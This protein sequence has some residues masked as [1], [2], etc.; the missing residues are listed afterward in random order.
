MLWKKEL[1]K[2]LLA[3]N[4]ELRS[5]PLLT[6]EKDCTKVS[7]AVLA[8]ASP[9]STNKE[10]CTIRH[11]NFDLVDKS[12][13]EWLCQQCSKGALVSGVLWGVF[14]V[15]DTKLTL[16]SVGRLPLTQRQRPQ[17]EL[18]YS[19]SELHVHVTLASYPGVPIPIWRR[20]EEER[21]VHTVM[22][23]RLI[24]NQLSRTVIILKIRT[25]N[26]NK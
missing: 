23:M 19:S 6:F 12:L 25:P 1:C 5:V 3:R 2:K 20:G 9:T 15:P 22:R 17:G 14:W 13:L 18:Y 4:L 10:C 24:S 26:F 7:D 16:K 11:A 8:S 21:L